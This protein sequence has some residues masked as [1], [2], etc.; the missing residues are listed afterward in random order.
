MINKQLLA[1]M[2]AVFA[3]TLF[4]CSDDEDV[5]ISTSISVTIDGETY[6]KSSDDEFTYYESSLGSYYYFSGSV[7]NGD[8]TL[9]LSFTIPELAVAEYTLAND[10]DDVDVSLV[11]WTSS[12]SYYAPAYV[13][14][15]QEDLSDYTVSITNVSDNSVSGEFTATLQK[16]YTEETVSVSGEFVAGDLYELWGDLLN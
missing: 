14:S 15:T 13:M 10:A 3:A 16:M 4:S 9:S 12:N 7:V 6:T 8:D 11:S 5:S 2:I 1:V